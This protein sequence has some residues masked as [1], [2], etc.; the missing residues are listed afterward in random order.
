VTA[1]IGIGL[2]LAA[3]AGGVLA[4]K[5]AWRRRP[6]GRWLLAGWAAIA[7][8]LAG[9]AAV[10]GLDMAVALALLVPSPMAFVML[11]TGAELKPRRAQRTPR[12]AVELPAAPSG[13]WRTILRALYAGP[14]SAA[15]ALGCAAAVALRAPLAEADRLVLGGMLVPGVWAAGMIW[16]TT[17]PRLA[18]IGLGLGASAVLAFALAAL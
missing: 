17:D 11:A 8:G 7:A 15:A 14:L 3:A 18:R 5:R 2:G 16:A 6:N 4:L 13:H 12:P 10:A 1:A 9:W